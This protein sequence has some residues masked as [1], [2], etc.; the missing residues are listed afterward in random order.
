LLEEIRKL[1]DQGLIQKKAIPEPVTP[2]PGMTNATN[3]QP[4]FSKM[5]NL[6]KYDA[7]LQALKRAEQTYTNENFR[8]SVQN[9]EEA[10]R[11]ARMVRLMMA[12]EKKYY[13]VRLIPAARDCLWRIASYAYIYGDAK[14]WPKIWK[15]NKH[16]IVDPDLI[17]PD[18]KFEIPA[19]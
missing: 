13:V 16:L 15:A 5:S 10:I 4:D 2:E 8:T 1:K 19:K 9:S 14:L 11:I 3:A 12:V 7:A 6:D 18:Q 17:Y